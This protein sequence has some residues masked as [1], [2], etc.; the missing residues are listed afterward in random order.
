VSRGAQLGLLAAGLAGAG[1]VALVGSAEAHESGNP[2]FGDDLLRLG[3]LLLGVALVVYLALPS[4]T[5]P[6]RSTE[7]LFERALCPRC[8]QANRPWAHGCR[9]CAAPIGPY[10]TLLPL[11]SVLA[12][13]WGIGEVVVRPRL[14]GLLLLGG[15]GVWL[16]GLLAYPAFILGSIEGD[17]PRDA[18]AWAGILA[19]QAFLLGWIALSLVSL[20]RMTGHYLAGRAHRRRLL[21]GSG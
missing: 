4:G 16:P 9:R 8:L 14:P 1:L 12:E 17:N 5:A 10:A 19:H 21:G 6:P 7:A 11:E 13:G 2:T 18:L 15:W 3:T 20:W